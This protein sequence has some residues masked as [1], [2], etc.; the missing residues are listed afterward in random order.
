[1][2]PWDP[3]DDI[4]ALDILKGAKKNDASPMQMV[5]SV[6]Y[7]TED[8]LTDK[9][10]AKRTLLSP[11]SIRHMRRVASK[12]N[13]AL[14]HHLHNGHLKFAHAKAIASTD[15]GDQKNLAERCMAGNWSVPKLQK[16]INSSGE[17]DDEDKARTYQQLSETIEVQ[18]GFPVAVKPEGRSD[19]KG[20]I[21]LK[22]NSLEE[23]D[24]ICDR[25]QV[26]PNQEW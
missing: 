17:H 10:I 7:L 16:I 8:Q 18:L 5:A 26:N 2:D 22:Y 19:N 13:P 6:A 25:L 14:F 15:N 4:E 24:S 12:L 9:D 1:M 11:S 23:F 3:L 21:V 20:A